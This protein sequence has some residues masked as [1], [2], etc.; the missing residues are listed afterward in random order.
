MGKIDS[1]T[2]KI[3]QVLQ[4][5]EAFRPIGDWVEYENQVILIEITYIFSYFELAGKNWSAHTT[6]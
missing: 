5:H 3:I 2:E 1:Y 6:A 4:Q